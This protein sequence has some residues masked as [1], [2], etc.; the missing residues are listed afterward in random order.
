MNVMNVKDNR[1]KWMWLF[2]ACLAAIQLYAVRELLAAFAIFI[3]GFSAIAFCVGVMFFL[4]KSWEA[5]V[6][7]A[8]KSRHPVFV[9]ARRGV[10][11]IQDWAWRPLRRPDSEPAR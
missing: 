3:L 8:A 10:S 1:R 9:T 7:W 11:A 5:G 6:T 4:H 2:L